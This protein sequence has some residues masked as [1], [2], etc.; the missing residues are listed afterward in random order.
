MRNVHTHPRSDIVAPEVAPSHTSGTTL[1][2]S[3]KRNEL[4]TRVQ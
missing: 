2:S 4:T 1:A 3:E